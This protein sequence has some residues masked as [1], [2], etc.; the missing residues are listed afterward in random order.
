MIRPQVP[1]IPVPSDDELRRPPPAPSPE[2]RAVTSP[3]R[4]AGAALGLSPRK[5]SDPLLSSRNSE[6]VVLF[7]PHQESFLVV[8]NALF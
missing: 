8:D 1:V 3:P 6:E 5:L 7:F 4:V 2:G